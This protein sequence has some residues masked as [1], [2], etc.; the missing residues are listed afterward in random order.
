MSTPNFEIE[1]KQGRRFWI[2]RSIV[3]IPFTFKVEDNKIY[4]LIEKRGKSVSD[5]GK[6]CC[7]CGYLDFDETLE[8]ACVR[9]VK[10][11]TGV[12]LDVKNVHF[13]NY[14]SSPMETRQNVGMR[15]ICFTQPYTEIDMSKIQTK[16]EVDDVMWLHIGDFVYGGHMK[17]MIYLN[18][19]KMKG[20]Y[21]AFGHDKLLEDMMIMYYKQQGIDV[22]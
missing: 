22:K 21:W 9:E 5:T 15:F 13:I 7:P 3:V 6:W 4:T 8:Q 1:D 2:S 19:F 10:E 17:E 18:R 16:D 11:E 20:L 12:E 14:N